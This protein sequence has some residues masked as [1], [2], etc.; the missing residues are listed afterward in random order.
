MMRPQRYRNSWEISYPALVRRPAGMLVITETRR[1]PWREACAQL[2]LR[3][4]AKER[5]RVH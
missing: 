1:L 5:S 2:I 3:T 4:Q